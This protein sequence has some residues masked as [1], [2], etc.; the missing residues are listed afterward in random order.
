MSPKLKDF[1]SSFGI[2]LAGVLLLFFSSIF[3]ASDNKLAVL[4]FPASGRR[5]AQVGGDITPDNLPKSKPIKP[6]A[7]NTDTYPNPLTAI[8]VIV[9]DT[10]TKNVLFKK[11]D[12]AIRPLA[13]IT[14][15]MTAMVLLDLSPNWSAAATIASGDVAGDHH[16]KE[17]E[18]FTLE[19]LWHAALI[20][21]SNTAINALVRSTGKTIEQF[22]MLMNQKAKDLHFDSAVFDEP[23][24]LSGKNTATV[25]DTAKLLIDA[26]KF[27]KIY[28]V[29]Q[30]GDYYIRPFGTG[31]ARQIWTTNWLLTNWVPNTFKAENIAGKTGYI[32]DSGYNFV[33][34]LSDDKQHTITVA[35]LGA[36]TN[37]ERFSEARDIA[38]WV[39]NQY[40]WP[41]Q[42]GYDELVE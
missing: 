9:L 32:E 16:V 6:V 30:M 39:F 22:V 11:N 26:M 21:S 2:M 38:Y 23:T 31:K 15:L 36:A 35:I 14:K 1:L 37:E 27:E 19:D 33:V 29:V 20:G 17:G 13:S 5:V 41:D 42:E 10:K 8:S 12:Q 25:F 4:Q 28:S 18:T 40:L 34:N 7:R 3:V 24:G